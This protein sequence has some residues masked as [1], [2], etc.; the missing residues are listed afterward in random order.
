MT[1]QGRTSDQVLLAAGYERVQP[2]AN[3]APWLSDTAFQQVYQF[4]S[5]STLVDV[6]R[7]Y[8]LWKLVEQTA[9]LSGDLLEVG[10]WRGG[11]GAII[12]SRAAL[13]ATS[14]R[15]R[16]Y[17]ADTFS[18]VVKA[19]ARD[20]YYR[21]GEHANTSAQLV[22][23]LLDE[24]ELDNATL[25]TGMFPEQT[26]EQVA[27]RTFCFCHIDVDVYQSA[28][29]VLEWIWPRLV[30]GGIVVYDD[31]GFYGCEGVTAHVN[32]N[33]PVAGRVVIHNLNGQAIMIKTA[34]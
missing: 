3:Y 22:S 7:C 11:T 6:Y 32:E 17:L 25:L 24:L 19:G 8:S 15:K 4:A 13:L 33:F 1:T 10:V 21:G 26:G 31:Y 16:V 9:A 12:A 27:D 5:G 20:T 29:D 34:G 18:G 28:S 2:L 30:V 14:E 23:S